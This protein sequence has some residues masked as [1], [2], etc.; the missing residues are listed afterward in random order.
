MTS[1]AIRKKE[2]TLRKKWNK[3]VRK[4]KKLSFKMNYSKD[5]KKLISP[6]DKNNL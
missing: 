1:L 4:S 5:K 3:R 2:P 6:S